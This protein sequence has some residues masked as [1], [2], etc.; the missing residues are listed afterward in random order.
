MSQKGP[1]FYILNNLAR[2]E[3]ILIIFGV[4][5]HEKLSHQV[6]FAAWPTSWRPPGAHRLSSR[7]PKVNYR[8][9][10]ARW[11]RIDSTINIVLSIIIIIR[12]S[13][14]SPE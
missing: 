4:Q 11:R 9:W 2:N 8:I 6:K 7:W 14:T 12:N 13:P 1:P 5:N 3:P 10:L